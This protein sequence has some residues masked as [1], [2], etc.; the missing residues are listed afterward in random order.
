M[1]AA[2]AAP[3]NPKIKALTVVAAKAAMDLKLR[4]RLDGDQ[5]RDRFWARNCGIEVQ[6]DIGGNI[7][8]GQVDIA[9]GRDGRRTTDLAVNPW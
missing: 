6:G 8:F 9:V 7:G 3:K 5:R 4:K 2:C 1:P